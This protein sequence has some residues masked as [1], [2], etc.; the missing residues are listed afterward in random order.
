MNTRYD[1]DTPIDRKGTG[2]VK[3][4]LV[5]SGENLDTMRVCDDCFGDDALLPL[6]VADMDFRAPQA[7]TDALMQRVSHGVFGYTL[8]TQDYLK[9]VCRWMQRRHGWAARPETIV[10]TPGIVPALHW[11]V[12]TFTTPGE[13]VIVQPPVYYPF[14]SATETTG[15]RIVRNPLREEDGHYRMDFDGLKQLAAQPDVT[16][17]I[18]CNPHNPV[19]RAW[20][21]EELCTFG[22]ICHDNGVTVISDEIHCDLT[23]FGTRHTSYATMPQHL[24]ADAVICTAPSKTFNLAGLQTSNIF[25]PDAD[26]RKAFRT[27][28][29]ANGMHDPNPL[30]MVAC[31]AAYDHCEDWL[32]QLLEYIEGSMLFVRDFLAQNIPAARM[33]LPEATYLAWM[34]FRSL[35]LDDLA[36]KRLMLE[37]A[38]VFLDDGYI[39]G[40]EGSGFER[41]NLASPRSMIQNALTR[42]AA[43]VT[44]VQNASATPE[45]LA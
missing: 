14:F 3:W 42:I 43:S 20:T 5:P 32:D 26:R 22:E 30:G 12:Q 6:W 16:C 25:V 27:T 7:I 11:L 34:D 44:T 4:Q 41:M 18:L 2:S 8:A 23:L 9:S 15:R 10:P 45:K 13:G 38:R 37:D 39:F 33:R 40:K 36:L 31:Q 21:A 19:G 17:A 35:G 29:A 1:F 28:L 24:L